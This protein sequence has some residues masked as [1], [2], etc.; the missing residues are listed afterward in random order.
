MSNPSLSEVTSPDLH[1]PEHFHSHRQDILRAPAFNKGTAFTQE[2][3]K[4]LGL[5][6]LLPSQ[7]ETLDVQVARSL[8]QLRAFSSGIEQYIFLQMLMNTNET[9]FYALVLRNLKECMPIIYTP[10]VGQAC[11]QFGSNFR[12]AQ[13]MTFSHED[14]GALR[15]M[16]DNWPQEKVDIIVVTDGSRILGLGD[17]GTNGM[18]I[19]IGK[20]SLYVAGSGFHPSTTL[21]MMLDLGTNNEQLLESPTYLGCKHKRIDDDEYMPFV[22]EFMAAVFDKWP[23]CLLQFED[24]SNAHAFGLLEQ[25]R[26][27]YRCFND[28]IQGTGAVVVSGIINALRVAK[29][30]LKDV[31][32]LFFGAGSAGVGVADTIVQLFV[33]NGFEVEEARSHF[34]FVDSRGLVTNNRGD[35]LAAHKVRFARKDVEEQQTQLIDVINY[36]KPN[37]MIGLSGQGG[38]FKQEHIEALTKFSENPIIFSLSNP[39]KNAECSAEQAYNWTKGTCIF[40]SGSPFDPVE[41]EGRTFVPGQGNNAFIFP[42]LGYGA[43]MAQARIITDKMILAASKAL[44]DFVPDDRIAARDIYPSVSDI[45]EISAQIAARVIKTAVEDGVSEM[46]IPA[47]HDELVEK[48]KATMYTAEYI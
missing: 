41:Y 32:L 27:K 47:T 29:L 9:L 31:R 8:S 42:G 20:L 48:V 17:L 33:D 25:Y 40:A 13:G 44:A 18:G 15:G 7:V 46:E 23:N 16:L 10:T 11:Q 35:T 6:G 36:V 38:S 19:P 28:D 21:P 5:R 45:R 3:R 26:D 4:K 43:W 37:V 2:E 12:V 22:E 1:R 24:F 34:W 30:D 14:K 39:T